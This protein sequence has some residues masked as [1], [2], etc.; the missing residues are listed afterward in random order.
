MKHKFSKLIIVLT[1]TTFVIAGCN[2][3]SNGNSNQSADANA[4]ATNSSNSTEMATLGGSN[5][6][7]LT[8][9]SLGDGDDSYSACAAYMS[10][11]SSLLQDVGYATALF[12]GGG[13]LISLGLFTISGTL[14]GA[15][16][17]CQENAG[18]ADPFTYTNKMLDKIE[19]QVSQV[20]DITND[21][22]NNLKEFIDHTIKNSVSAQIDFIDDNGKALTKILHT[23]RNLTQ[24]D[25][26]I[27]RHDNKAFQVAQTQCDLDDVKS[28]IK[29]NAPILFSWRNN[30]NEYFSDSKSLF[31]KHMKSANEDYLT[32]IQTPDKSGLPPYNYR[33]FIEYY[34]A[35]INHYATLIPQML[36][37]AMQITEVE[38][39][40]M[41][42]CP[43]SIGMPTVNA[44]TG[45]ADLAG[46]F[47]GAT[48]TE[49][50]GIEQ[51]IIARNNLHR[52]KNIEL[53]ATQ[54]AINDSL[55]QITNA[56]AES[57]LNSYYDKN[58]IDL[59]DFN[60]A[61]ANPNS[62]VS[63]NDGLNQC[64]V[65]NFSPI[66]SALSSIGM[67]SLSVIC[68][69][70]E[71]NSTYTLEKF[72]VDFP[73][74]APISKVTGTPA[75]Y[76]QLT[77][78]KYDPLLGYPH[79]IEKTIESSEIASMADNNDDQQASLDYEYA[80]GSHISDPVNAP[81]AN[82]YFD[83]NIKVFNGFYI[84][85]NTY[86]VDADYADRTQQQLITVAQL[87]S[88]LA[89][90]IGNGFIKHM[91]PYNILQYYSHAIGWL[92]QYNEASAYGHKFRTKLTRYSAP[93]NNTI[94]TNYF[95]T[96]MQY[97]FRLS[98]LTPEPDCVAR[99]NYPAPNMQQLAFADGT[100]ITI[101]PGYPTNVRS[102]SPT[103][104]LINRQKYLFE[105]SPELA[106][107]AVNPNTITNHIYLNGELNKRFG[108]ASIGYKS[109]EIMKS[110]NGQYSLVFNADDNLLQVKDNSDSNNDKLFKFTS[111]VKI[112]GISF[113]RGDIII[114]D[115]NQNPLW[116]VSQQYLANNQAWL[117]DP[118]AELALDDKGNLIVYTSNA[119]NNIG[120]TDSNIKFPTYYTHI[121][122]SSPSTK[123]QQNRTGNPVSESAI[124]SL[125]YTP[126]N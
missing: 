79:F 61:A 57:V 43:K 4:N 32:L 87:D 94:A 73:R 82:I 12:P 46:V 110:D 68:N 1:T 28:E 49:S 99:M 92:Y 108:Y 21:I 6:Q 42:A 114:Y 34:N 124:W 20:L 56:Q 27:L 89:S 62:G 84:P 64:T 26:Y 85:T 100:T 78:L 53:N 35:S 113:A 55:F 109:T 39:L 118:Y 48:I 96:N 123:W 33:A 31:W 125:Q 7:T 8:G 30:F 63:N 105:S 47:T 104:Q 66:Q 112:A 50:S 44:A 40:Y 60:L 15:G 95:S 23:Y 45:F 120:Y 72:T 24:Y 80:Y 9:S 70:S 52:I 38:L 69:V 67:S 121:L 51:F 37:V 122:W 19:T 41:Y 58:I 106:S 29:G 59:T 11:S 22:N 93:N 54:S 5:Y 17:I 36:A 97:F 74:G 117:T 71:S 88:T 111:K 3:G 90:T 65:V 13:I 98:C 18:V 115:E 107:W 2:S 101:W 81:I 102:T 126:F 10:N 75:N 25:A 76:Y 103:P 16:D 119:L 91:G 14:M 77:D 83:D 86:I 116:S